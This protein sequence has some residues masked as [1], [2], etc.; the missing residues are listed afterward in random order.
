MV[1]PRAGYSLVLALVVVIAV[2]LTPGLPPV[3]PMLRLMSAGEASVGQL[4]VYLAVA[5]LMLGA[6]V[7]A[8]H[9]IAV[10]RD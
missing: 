2:P 1:V 9:H 6:A 4:S 8:T 3:N 5:V 7:T 10:R